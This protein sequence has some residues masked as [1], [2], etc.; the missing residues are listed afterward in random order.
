M[1]SLDVGH[2]CTLIPIFMHWRPV[3]WLPLHLCISAGTFKS[4]LQ[5]FCFLVPASTSLISRALTRGR[6]CRLPWFWLFCFVIRPQRWSSMILTRWS[7]ARTPC[8]WG[9]HRGDSP[10]PRWR[11]SASFTQTN[12]DMWPC[13]IL[14]T[15]SRSIRL[16][17]SRKPRG[18]GVWIIP[19]CTSHRLVR[20]T[21]RL[22]SFSKFCYVCKVVF[23]KI[24]WRQSGP[25]KKKNGYRLKDDI[26]F[27]LNWNSH[28]WILGKIGL[29]SFRKRKDNIYI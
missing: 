15:G 22:F 8:T 16:T 25:L 24:L 4:W 7:N 29:N 2:F 14:T 19:G 20:N 6:G 3:W 13:T 17:P 18:T 26:T 28:I 27:P 12:L 10:D 1:R 5:T 11:R 9:P 23:G 21:K